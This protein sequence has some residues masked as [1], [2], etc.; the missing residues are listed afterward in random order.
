VGAS[1]LEAAAQQQISEYSS[2]VKAGIERIQAYHS[3]FHG[4]NASSN[5]T[6][7]AVQTRCS[8]MNP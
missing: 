6:H 2:G 8:G 4:S 1:D 7:A 5:R 3:G